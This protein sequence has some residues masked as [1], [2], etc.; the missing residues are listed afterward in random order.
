MSNIKLK[1]HYWE[2]SGVFDK[3]QNKTQREL[4]A[5]I[6]GKVDSSAVG[7]ASGV[8]SLDSSGKVPIGQLP[9][10]SVLSDSS[11]NPVQNKV[12]YGKMTSTAQADAIYHLGFY[13]DANG[14]LCQ[15]E[16]N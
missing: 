4:N 13:L 2:A 12:I 6:P 1:D 3:V 8:A 7:A 16:S 11:E 14:D 5:E 15:V 10:D 9:V